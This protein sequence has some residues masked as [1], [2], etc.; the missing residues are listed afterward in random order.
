MKTF[1]LA[2]FSTLSLSLCAMPSWPATEGA[3]LEKNAKPS[4]IVIDNRVLAN[5]NNQPISVMDIMKKMDT[6]FYRDF[7][8][9][10]ESDVARYQYYKGHWK[11]V[12]DDLINNELMFTDAKRKKIEV[13]HGDVRQELDRLYGPSIITNLDK[14]GLTFDDVWDITEKELYVRRMIGSILYLK[15]A[16]DASPEDLLS[17]YEKYVQEHPKADEWTYRMVT[18]RG[19]NAKENASI[20]SD[21]L[22]ESDLNKA[23]FK[24]M[25]MLFREKIK[26]FEPKE[27]NISETFKLKGTEISD[28]HQKVL[29]QLS[30]SSFSEP[31]EEM[32]RADRA[33]LYRIFYLANYTPG[34]KTDF[35]EV[36]D[37][38]KEALIQS[39]VDTEVSSYL[40][41]LRSQFGVSQDDLQ[42]TALQ[43]FQPFMLK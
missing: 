24:T 33:P 12:L 16:F 34:G 19:A 38:L 26:T 2:F 43:Q 37:T 21:I 22:K 40:A 4:R 14:I 1:A 36:E 25:A 29:K 5:V 28:N 6:H 42:Q 35:S 3:H 11:Y 8:H 20:A 39:K 30:P 18:F 27:I 7:P 10:I 15:G 9:L 32:S 13:T 23:D 41:E 31:V 17:A